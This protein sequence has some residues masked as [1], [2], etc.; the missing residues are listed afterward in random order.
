M[1]LFHE[2]IRVVIGY[3]CGILCILHQ[4]H[5]DL[6]AGLNISISG[7]QPCFFNLQQS[8]EC[9]FS[10]SVSGGSKELTQ[11]ETAKAN[12]ARRQKECLLLSENHI[13]MDI[14][15]GRDVRKIIRP[16]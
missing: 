15:K 8:L 14:K 7:S 5:C 12:E 9:S 11:P 16:L 1:S 6:I 2:K 13:T 3:F 10:V 4:L